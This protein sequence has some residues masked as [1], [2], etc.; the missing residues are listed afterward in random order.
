MLL[1]SKPYC[2]VP[3]SGV[4]PFWVMTTPLKLSAA[5]PPVTASV[6]SLKLSPNNA[7]TVLP[8][9]SDGSS[10]MSGN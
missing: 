9:L 3:W 7:D 4:E 1:A 6:A 5:L 2:H 8:A 10:L